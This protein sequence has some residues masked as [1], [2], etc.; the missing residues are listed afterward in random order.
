[1][2]SKPPRALFLVGF[3][4]AGKTSVGRA[5]AARLGW[6]FLDLDQQVEEREQHSVAEIFAQSGEAAFRR[7]ETS[8]LQE[9]LT[10]LDRSGP[11]VVA[12]GGGAPIAEENSSLLT[13]AGEPEVFLDA[14]Y[15]VLLDRCQSAGPS[16]PLFGDEKRA[17]E[18][19]ESRRP[20]YMRARLR[21][22]TN[23]KS[24]DQV[25]AEIERSLGL[26][27]IPT[28]GSEVQSRS[29]L[30]AVLVL[31]L[32]A[33]LP[34]AAGKDR[35][36]ARVVDS[37]SYSIF[38][39]GRQVG[40]ETFSIQQGS[41]FSVATAEV[42]IEGQAGV[43]AQNSEL[44]VGSDGNLRRYRWRQLSP[45]NAETVVEYKDQF[46]IQRVVNT[47]GAKPREIAFMAPPSTVVLDDNFFTHRQVLLWRYLAAGCGPRILGACKLE[48]GQFGVLVPR[49]QATSS[50]AVEYKGKEKV[51]IRGA[52]RELDRFNLQADGVVW[53][54]WLDADYKLVRILIPSEN[55]EVVRD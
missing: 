4:G 18:L 43:A 19:Y 31:F 23:G 36:D 45:G 15:E 38:V 9:L 14:P 26:Q 30:V 46:L 1:M 29:V 27:P 54:F 42:K 40:T 13:K 52:P 3:M 24:V 21:V 39:N 44:E 25:V 2:P 7:A 11:V 10:S 49:Q 8:A 48:R 50:V 20:H 53:V 37:G 47:A 35:K 28:R 32:A 55:V 16:R 41:D 22:D 34:V 5:L 17:R 33:A 51:V 6:R 12:L